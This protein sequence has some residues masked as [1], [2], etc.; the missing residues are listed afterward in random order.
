MRNNILYASRWDFTAGSVW[1][2][3]I[4]ILT[5]YTNFAHRYSILA[6]SGVGLC[7]SVDVE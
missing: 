4:G 7:A 1:H 6:V 2:F 3:V 5:C